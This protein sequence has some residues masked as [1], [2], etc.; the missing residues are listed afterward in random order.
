MIFKRLAYNAM[1]E[2]IT[3]NRGYQLRPFGVL[4]RPDTLKRHIWRDFKPEQV[5]NWKKSIWESHRETASRLWKSFVTSTISHII[6]PIYKLRYFLSTLQKRINMKTVLI[7][8]ALVICGCSNGK[9]VTAGYKSDP[10]TV[11]LTRAEVAIVRAVNVKFKMLDEKDRVLDMRI[12]LLEDDLAVVKNILKED[13][14]KA[15]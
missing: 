10:N 5:Q 1:G 6:Q 7:L 9:A 8:A 12:Q 2:A 14:N 3:A 13:P 15:L 11:Q 4:T